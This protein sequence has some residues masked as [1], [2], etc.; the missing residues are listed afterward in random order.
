MIHR[1]RLTSRIWCRFDD[2]FKWE[3]SG[4]KMTS[5]ISRQDVCVRHFMQ[6]GMHMYAYVCCM[7]TDTVCSLLT[8]IVQMF[9]YCLV[10]FPSHRVYFDIMCTDAYFIHYYMLRIVTGMN[11]IYIYIFTLLYVRVDGLFS[12]GPGVFLVFCLSLD[13]SI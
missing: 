8:S 10:Y 9:R 1:L 3:V 7:H 6:Y 4:L 12:A 2:R 13:V 11:I 5:A